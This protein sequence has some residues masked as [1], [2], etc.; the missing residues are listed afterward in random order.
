MTA[1]PLRFQVGARTLFRVE[2]HLLRV[3]HSLD[4][5][6]AGCIRALPVLSRND[7]GYLLTSVPAHRAASAI[8]T[9]PGLLVHRKQSYTR[10]Y[11]DLGLE[12]SSY[13]QGLSSN[14]RSTIRR[15]A[16]RFAEADDGRID[17]RAYRT[18]DELI[19]FH[20]A[21]R[22]VSA[23]SY[24]ERLLD[25]G[26]PD[27]DGFRTEMLALA[28][29]DQVRA[30]VLYL[31]GQPVAYLYCPVSGATVVYDRLGYDPAHRDLSPGAVLQSEALRMLM[32]E[33]RFRYFDF[34]EGE[35]QHKRTM[36]TD[37]VECVDLLALR[38]TLAN[39][40]LIV[41][42]T[43]FDQLVAGSKR[44]LTSDRLRIA[45]RRLRRA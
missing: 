23:Q 4:D 26:L 42:M 43:G 28:A 7:D 14:T 32:E 11:V 36:A 3:G 40:A 41:A 25:A 9:V 8:V 20:A 12:W 10:H 2:R 44:M 39:R 35:G 27:N 45:T 6:S 38:P 21:A 34:T 33:R 15:K 37:G 31:R 24:Q 29:Q 30:W 19:A 22:V 1:V 13:L 17:V 18:P 16:K 5:A